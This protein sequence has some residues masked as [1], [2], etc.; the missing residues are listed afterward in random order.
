MARPLRLRDLLLGA[1]LVTGLAAAPPLIG[2]SGGGLNGGSLDRGDNPVVGSLPCMVDPQLLDL[3]WVPFD[4]SKPN[5]GL[6][7][8]APPTL[9]FIGTPELNQELYDAYGAGF[10]YLDSREGWLC[11]G[12]VESGTVVLDRA[13]VAAG[14]TELWQF[15]PDGYLG[16]NLRLTSSTGKVDQPIVIQ[17]N[18]IALQTFAQ[19]PDGIGLVELTFSGPN[20]S[21]LP[22]RTVLVHLQGT[23]VAVEFVP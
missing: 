5:D 8:S 1:A 15:V 3:F 12:L 22:D 23:L 13:L 4:R 10:G 20:G 14:S 6:L 2:G 7:A 19:L 18:P 11:M 21:N 16:G 17:D 9:G